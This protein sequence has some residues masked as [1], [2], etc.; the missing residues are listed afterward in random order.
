MG[1]QAVLFRTGQFSA[2]TN[3]AFV[4]HGRHHWSG[5]GLRVIEKSG[6]NWSR[7]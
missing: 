1:R 4:A 3:L 2:A 5:D 7:L 6:A